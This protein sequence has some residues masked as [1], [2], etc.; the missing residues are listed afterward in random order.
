MVWGRARL[1]QEAVV[2]MGMAGG[3]Q[4]LYTSVMWARVKA[5]GLKVG[6]TWSVDGVASEVFGVKRSLYSKGR[7][8]G[9]VGL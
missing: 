1:T 5:S 3:C 4:L 9:V 7:G 2:L 6:G 8:I